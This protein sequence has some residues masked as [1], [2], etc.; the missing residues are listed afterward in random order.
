[1]GIVNSD[2]SILIPCHYDILQ[3]E[4][5]YYHAYKKRSGDY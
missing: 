4:N 2:G 1:M 5:K 3:K